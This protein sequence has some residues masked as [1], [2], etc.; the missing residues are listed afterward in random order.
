MSGLGK[1]FF[2]D[3]RSVRG[4]Q[5][6][7]GW[8]IWESNWS[9]LPPLLPQRTVDVLVGRCVARA[10]QEVG[11]KSCLQPKK[12]EQRVERLE[13]IRLLGMGQVRTLALGGET[14]Q[15]EGYLRIKPFQEEKTGG[16]CEAVRTM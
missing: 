6:L 13:V 2:F 8:Q 15:G 11:E 14:F 12:K 7:I 9:P 5:N 16:T 10:A 3:R 4:K 1:R